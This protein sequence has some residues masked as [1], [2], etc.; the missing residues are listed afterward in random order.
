[1]RLA[2]THWPHPPN[3]AGTIM[4]A[5]KIQGEAFHPILSA[6]FEAVARAFSL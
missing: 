3:G 1:M 4:T 6:R 2:K 5:S